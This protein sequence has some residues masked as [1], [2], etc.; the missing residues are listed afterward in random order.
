M[1]FLR[2]FVRATIGPVPC[3]ILLMTACGEAAPSPSEQ[4]PVADHQPLA[5]V[6]QAPPTLASDPAPRDVVAVPATPPK[7]R[8]PEA[9]DPDTPDTPDTPDEEA[10]ATAPQEKDDFPDPIATID[11]QPLAREAFR[12]ELNRLIPSDSKITVAR[13]RRIES[14]VLNRLIEERLVRRAIKGAK[15]TLTTDTVDQ[16]FE[17][18]KRRFRDESQFDNFLKGGHVTVASIRLKLQRKAELEALL[19]A[20]G[21][22]QVT[23]PDIQAF[24]KQNAKFYVQEEAVQASHLLVQLE[25]K[26]SAE[27]EEA[28][29][30]KIAA[31]QK[32]LK[33]G[34]SFGDVARDMS[35]GPT[36]SRD[37]NLGFFGRGK[38]VPAFEKAA[39]ALKDGEISKPIR[40]RFGL[41]LIRVIARRPERK[42]PFNEVRAEIVQSLQNKKFFIERRSLLAELHKRA[43]I[44]KYLSHANSP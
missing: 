16:A 7:T 21:S 9:V 40:T 37:G 35:E 25:L 36:R 10:P 38:M 43:L 15:I 27:Q 22:L 42:R 13:R 23:E 3:L 8:P 34:E 18:Y 1:R 26:A 14:N 30:A 5:T 4:P 24:F 29:F 33:H 32:R 19:S 2:S 11:G 41:H 31:A 17:V 44:V 12:E 6:T 20:R 28:A 39:W